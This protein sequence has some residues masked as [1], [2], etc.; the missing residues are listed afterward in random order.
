MEARSVRHRRIAERPMRRL[1][2]GAAVAERDLERMISINCAHGATHLQRARRVWPARPCISRCPRPRN[3]RRGAAARGSLPTDGQAARPWLP[4]G[5]HA[6]DRSVGPRAAL[7]GEGLLDGR[8]RREH[9]AGQVPRTRATAS[10]LPRASRGWA[11]GRLSHRPL[12]AALSRP[13]GA[14]GSLGPDAR[15]PAGE[16]CRR[17]H[18][19]G[20]RPLRASDASCRPVEHAA[21]QSLRRFSISAI[22]FAPLVR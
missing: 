5:L 13:R 6:D 15:L 3:S 2:R 18:A 21:V 9:G 4:P 22:S 14:M 20:L 11:S 12:A 19:G 7:D 17:L 16:S 1:G 8:E 10:G